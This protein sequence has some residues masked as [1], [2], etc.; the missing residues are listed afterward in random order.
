MTFTAR[1]EAW[2]AA[3]HR[4]LLVALVLGSALLRVAYW[5]ELRDGPM[6]L[7][8]LRTQSDM[9][10]FD[11]WARAIAA[12]DWL[13]NGAYHPLMAWQQDCARQ[14]FE[15]APAARRLYPGTDLEAAR[16]LWNHWLGGKAFHQEPL[17]VYLVA[18]T[19]RLFG[20]EVRFVFYWQMCLGVAS[21]ALIW[22]LAR[23]YFGELTAAVAALI[24]LL[25]A[26]LMFYEV[27]LVRTTLTAFIGLAL[28]LLTDSA[29]ERGTLRAWGLAGLAFGVSLLCQTTFATYIL[30]SAA[31]LALKYR[32][33][34]RTLVR[35]GGVMALGVA[36]GMS[37]AIAR[38]VV[39]G[40]KPLTWASV[41]PFSFLSDNEA[42]FDPDEGPQV[43]HPSQVRIMGETD[44][45][46]S[47]IVAASLKSHRPGGWA[48]LLARKFAKVWH[49][50]EEGDNQN[51][52]YGRRFSTAL[53]RM[54]FTFYALSPLAIVG[55]LLALRDVRRCSPLYLMI[56]AGVALGVL[57][58]PFSRYRVPYEAAMIPFGALTVS[59]LV[60]WI[61][62]RRWRHVAALALL[63]A[64][65]FAWTS[66]PI[67]RRRT[68]IRRS[69]YTAPLNYFWGPRIERAR[70]AEEAVA[71]YEE[72]LEYQP[73]EIAALASHPRG[74]TW[75]QAELSVRYAE[76][77]D[78]YARALAAAGRTR[79]SA[80]ARDMADFLA[81]IARSMSGTH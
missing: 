10:F 15:M 67:P 13:S 16:S 40:V 65:L 21:N 76:I 18:L 26:P 38:N 53:D 64:A 33:E 80:K 79:D 32:K 45:R 66:R 25:F 4:M 34:P 39:V 20:P 17:Y 2:L 48:W 11:A 73:P 71:I 61:E 28:A 44:G 35:L 59:T 1:A 49:W 30:G 52:Y 14:W 8:H 7:A 70:S 69:D 56:V 24:A 58:A 74:I 46:M 37:P 55:L 6:V 50:Y 63:T 22:Q 31:L 78:G 19:Y 43:L 42:S 72:A 51:F 41:G 54:P 60:A 47:G 68:L 27:A 5:L 12:G 29:L 36:L 77:Y 81:V 62:A 23:R 57:A 75:F 3:R 9:H